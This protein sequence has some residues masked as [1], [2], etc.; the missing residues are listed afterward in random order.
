MFTVTHWDNKNEIDEQIFAVPVQR[1]IVED[2]KGWARQS[3]KTSPKTCMQMQAK[4]NKNALQRRKTN[5][6]QTLHN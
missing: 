3:Y 5:I 4:T 1:L 2:Y 6:R